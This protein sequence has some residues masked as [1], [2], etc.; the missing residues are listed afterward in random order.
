MGTFLLGL[1]LGANLAW[2]GGAVM[3]T[4]P[5]GLVLGAN[6][7]WIFMELRR[8]G[9]WREF[10]ARRRGS[11]PPPP[12][13]KPA[14]PAGPP[15]GM[16]REWIWSPSQMAECAGSCWEA[17]DLGYCVCGALWRDVPAEPIKPQPQVGASIPPP[18]HP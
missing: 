10:N 13:R 4:F 16:R 17:Q 11:N 5:L 14:S 8:N 2:A 7:A 12:G 6:L 18:S 15:P 3:G 9:H 1:V